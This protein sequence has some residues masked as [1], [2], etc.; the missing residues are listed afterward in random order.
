[1]NILG[2][3]FSFYLYPHST[4]VSSHA[5]WPMIFLQWV[6]MEKGIMEHS[7]LNGLWTELYYPI[8]NISSLTGASSWLL[9]VES[10]LSGSS[11]HLLLASRRQIVTWDIFNHED[12]KGTDA[13][14]SLSFRAICKDFSLGSKWLLIIFAFGEGLTLF[15]P[16]H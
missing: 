2:S 16:A 11:K 14:Y 12:F 6:Y 3:R 15:A 1:M 4:V 13:V 7:S 5:F 8:S 9:L 10:L